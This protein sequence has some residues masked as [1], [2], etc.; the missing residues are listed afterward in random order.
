M[1][2]HPSKPICLHLY[3]LMI[4]GSTTGYTIRDLLY[5]FAKFES[6]LVANLCRG[7]REKT[8]PI[9]GISLGPARSSLRT[10]KQAVIP[11]K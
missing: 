7:T 5:V 3:P 9:C 6:S 8:F 2:P 4:K 11:P 10:R 1:Q